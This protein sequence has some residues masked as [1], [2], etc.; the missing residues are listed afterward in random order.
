MWSSRVA[1]PHHLPDVE[2]AEH[3]GDQQHQQGDR[4]A[5]AELALEVPLLEEVDRHQ[6]VPRVELCLADQE[7]R[8][9]EDREVPD[10]RQARENEENRPQDREGDVAED[11]D[12]SR[13]IHLGGLDEL[14]RHLR[15]PG[16]HRDGNEWQGSPDDQ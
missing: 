1:L 4:G 5:A 14:A 3:G 13:A 15:Q 7:V 12:R 16:V 6:V 11:A 2:D 9:R 8:L 10:D